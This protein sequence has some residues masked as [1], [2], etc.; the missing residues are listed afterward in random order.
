MGASIARISD[1]YQ[2]QVEPFRGQ[3]EDTYIILFDAQ[4]TAKVIIRVTSGGGRS[5]FLLKKR[6]NSADLEL[7]PG[8]FH[9]KG[10]PEV[11]ATEPSLSPPQLGLQ[12]GFLF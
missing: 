5:N 11:R 7:G 12:D 8:R 4:S 2:A 9:C 6:S 1:E 10:R 3:L